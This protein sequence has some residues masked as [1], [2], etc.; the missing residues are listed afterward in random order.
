M[1]FLDYDVRA[2]AG[3]TVVVELD[4]QANVRLL[5]STNFSRYRRGERHEF[6]GGLA[7]ASPVRLTV[8]R[9]GHWHVVVDLGG[10]AGSVHASVAV[11][12]ARG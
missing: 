3:D 6:F 9:N 11:V 12:S 7:T 10:Y 2:A 5:D 4:R 8:P 1:K